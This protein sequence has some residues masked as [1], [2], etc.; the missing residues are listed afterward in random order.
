MIAPVGNLAD[1]LDLVDERLLVVWE[2]R[3]RLQRCACPWPCRV[4]EL[5]P[6]WS[7]VD[8][9]TLFGVVRHRARTR[10]LLFVMPAGVRATA[11]PGGESGAGESC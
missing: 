9:P 1:E 2:R 8:V 7:V 4:V 6:K 3:N 5:G 10:D 11:R